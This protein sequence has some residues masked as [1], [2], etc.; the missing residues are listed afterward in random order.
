MLY[1]VQSDCRNNLST[2]NSKEFDIFNE[3]VLERSCT[4]VPSVTIYIALPVRCIEKRKL[5]VGVVQPGDML[6]LLL[7]DC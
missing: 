5:G 1:T 6:C 2:T 4:L 3:N 7:K